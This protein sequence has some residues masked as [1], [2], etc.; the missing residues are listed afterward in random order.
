MDQRKNNSKDVKKFR[1]CFIADGQYYIVET[2]LN[3]DQQPSIL[4]IETCE[5][6]TPVNMPKFLRVLRDVTMDNN[7]S[8]NE[9]CRTGWRMPE[10]DKK[11]HKAAMVKL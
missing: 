2:F 8:R 11:N 5:S 3:V 4:R 7:Y 10:A 9:L 1:Q 6:S